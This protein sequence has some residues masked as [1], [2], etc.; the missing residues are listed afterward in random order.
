MPERFGESNEDCGSQEILGATDLELIVHPNSP[1]SILHFAFYRQIA[2][3][4]SR[5]WNP[6][7]PGDRCLGTR[8]YWEPFRYTPIRNSFSSSRALKFSGRR[9]TAARLI[10]SK[11][12]VACSIAWQMWLPFRSKC[13]APARVAAVQQRQIQWKLQKFL[14]PGARSYVGPPHLP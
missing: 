13:G 3:P 9:A 12:V 1:A 4:V 8:R 2:G 5:Q 10:T 6:P 11:V 14:G 7:C